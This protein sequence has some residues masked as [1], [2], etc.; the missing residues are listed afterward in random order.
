MTNT[1]DKIKN[2]NSEF[3]FW[4]YFTKHK[5]AM[6][7]YIFS[8]I[9]EISA[10][11]FATLYLAKI[12]VV[13]TEKSYFV[14]IKMFVILYL[15]YI[16]ENINS[17]FRSVIYTKTANTVINA[18]RVDVAEQAF[19]VSD[20]SYSEHNNANF[21]QRISNDPATIFQY[22]T[23]YVSYISQIITQ[24]IVISYIAILN[25][26]V[27]LLIVFGIIVTFFIEKYRKQIYRRNWKERKNL[28]EKADSLLHEVVR[29]QKDIK[30]LNLETKLQTKIYDA[31]NNTA[32]QSIKTDV[33]NR[34]FLHG[35]NI[36]INIVIATLLVLSL[37]LVKKELI[38]LAVFMMI[39][40]YRHSLR[41][42]AQLT[43]E[44]ITFGTEISLAVGRINE[45]Y[46]NENYELES[47]GKRNLKNIKGSI[48]FDNVGF[49][50]T[51]Y[52]EKTKKEIEDELK[53]N[54]KHKIKKTVL[55]T[56]P[57]GKN[58]VFKNLSFEIK[59]NTTV[60]FVGKSGCGK[61]TIL[62]LIAKMYNADSGKI[63]I[64]DVNIKTLSKETIRSSIALV[65]QFPYIF[66]M[67]IKENLLLVQ[68]DA[69]DKEIDEAIKDAALD[70]FVNT[71]P[72]KLNT[73]VGESGVKLSG[74]QRQRLAIARVLLKKSS[75]IIFDESTSSLDNLAQNKVKESIDNIKG[76]S[77]VVIVAHRLSTVKGADKIFYLDKGEIIDQGTFKE[78]YARNKS[79]K[80]M[81]L[82]EDV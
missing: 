9:L 49:S 78:L 23:M 71:L 45:L 75:I 65:N 2:N 46:E 52:R 20:K 7:I 66:D 41:T 67:T 81:F 32:K 24:V 57:T 44:I 12:L 43:S 73:R 51:Q 55:Q 53:Y 82:A 80:A 29:S 40:T 11:I 77:T 36:F 15:V 17:F 39:Y 21:T 74:G 62:N 25:I 33:T 56:V 54:K 4:P 27:G 10:E 63:L 42:L 31:V 28:A 72:E 30:S 59:P 35:R 16:F 60:A 1:K 6:F 3:R 13:I 26:Y 5:L 37:I 8:F 14:A 34:I 70:D 38:T 76:K 47:F 58:P 64:D 50:Y 22:L 19:R 68:P 79:F 18:M 69:T 48:K 61:T